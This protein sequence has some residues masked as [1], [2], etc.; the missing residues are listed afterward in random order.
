MIPSVFTPRDIEEAINLNSKQVLSEK[1]Q[2]L[3]N[4]D[5]IRDCLGM[6]GMFTYS[7]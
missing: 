7:N 6:K 5:Y 1:K 4:V 3:S 2:Y